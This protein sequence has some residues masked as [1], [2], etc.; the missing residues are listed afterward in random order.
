M[1]YRVVSKTTEGN[2]VRVRLSPWPQIMRDQRFTSI[3]LIVAAIIILLSAL[4]YFKLQKKALPQ[5]AQDTSVEQSSQISKPSP[6]NN[7]QTY[8]LDVSD[9]TQYKQTTTEG[10]LL[11]THNAVAV[12]PLDLDNPIKKVA[13][14]GSETVFEAQTK[15]GCWN[16]VIKENDTSYRTLMTFDTPKTIHVGN[17]RKIKL[18]M[19]YY[20]SHPS[21]DPLKPSAFCIGYHTTNNKWVWDTTPIQPVLDDNLK[22]AHAEVNVEMNNIDALAILFNGTTLIKAISFEA[23]KTD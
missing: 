1:V 16:Q 13:K 20:I 10:N 7:F 8:T 9:I 3:I 21:Y 23:R 11:I 17:I 22:Q 5:L 4:G 18:V 15:S 6:S 2:L 12:F 14:V 19:P